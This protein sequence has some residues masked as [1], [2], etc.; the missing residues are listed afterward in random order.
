MKMKT[1]QLIAAA[2]VCAVAMA[3]AIAPVNAAENKPNIVFILTDNLG[4][5]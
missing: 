4:Y 1:P 2:L 3:G 5:G